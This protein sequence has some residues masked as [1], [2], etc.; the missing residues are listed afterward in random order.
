MTIPVVLICFFVFLPLSGGAL[1]FAFPERGRK[2]LPLLF[3]VNTILTGY[4]IL[5]GFEDSIVVSGSFGVEIVFD[6]PGLI[7]TLMNGIVFLAVSLSMAERSLPPLAMSLI[8]MLH[9]TAN[10]VFISNDLF[11][12]F[13]CVDLAGILGFLLIR[14]GRKPRQIW[15][16]VKYLITANFGMILYLLGCLQVYTHTGSF[17]ISSIADVPHGAVVL[18]LTGLSVKG[19]ILAMGLWLPEAHGEA[20]AEVSALLSGVIV[21]V[22]LAPMFRIASFSPLAHGFLSFIG[23]L[24]AIWGVAYAMAEKD[25]K[26]ML[27]YSTLSQVGFAISVPAVGPFY[28]ASHGIAKAWLFLSAGKM[29]D[30]SIEYLQRNGV[31]ISSW[32][33][34]TIGSLVIAGMP[35][36][37]VYISKGLAMSY[38]EGWRL[39][40]LYLASLGTAV[41]YSRLIFIP[42]LKK[43]KIL[44]G[45]GF[46]D[47]IL[48][49]ALIAG[50]AR[51]GAYGL[52]QVISSII[53]LFSGISL[54]R[55]LRKRVVPVLPYWPEEIDHIMGLTVLF[56]ILV[57]VVLAP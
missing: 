25:I 38:L 1:L 27:A 16:G 9:G 36:S 18:L 33:P 21:K 55:L 7:L 31:E 17:S 32:L 48:L 49:G 28:A 30:R 12:I 37:A 56:C 13:V 45:S 41:Y 54:Y 3:L 20:E 24:A 34:L 22:G 11:N 39:I 23:P 53:L 26:K 14:M 52:S 10:A 2:L 19:G 4:M 15:S 43:G 57:W 44:R 8:S 46:S 50:G 42:P 35:G 5:M 47:L 29:P 40:L 6:R 51:T